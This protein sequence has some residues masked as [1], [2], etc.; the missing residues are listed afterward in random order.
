M[1]FF[2]TNKF[3]VY[4]QAALGIL[5]SMASL[6]AILI[7]IIIGKKRCRCN[8]RSDANLLITVLLFLYVYKGKMEWRRHRMAAEERSTLL[9][10]QA[11]EENLDEVSTFSYI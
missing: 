3:I 6:S 4:F 9:G 8:S 1:R 2:K 10:P 5:G 11:N 7:I